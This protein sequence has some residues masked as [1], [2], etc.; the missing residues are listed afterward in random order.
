MCGRYVTVTKIR[1]IEQRFGVKA[2][3]PELYLPSPNVSVGQLAPVILSSRPD[4]LRFC[5]FG[6][7]PHWATKNMYVLNARCEGDHNQDDDPRYTGAKGILT[8]PMFRKAIRSQRCLVIADAVIEGP[9]EEKLKKP[10]CVYM[11]DGRR[12]F[13][14]AGIWDEW[15]NQATGELITSFA[16]L[17]TAAN[18]LM[19]Q[20]GHHR[21]PLFLFPHQEKIWLDTQ[22][23]LEEIT[24]MMKPF[25]AEELNA[26]PL[27][28]EIRSPKSRGMELLTPIGV[29]LVAETGFEVSEEIRLFGMG[30]G[31]AKERRQSENQ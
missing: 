10:F 20:I 28:P 15:L 31:R 18:E 3:F 1:E 9:K 26:Y 16:I 17:T 30:E 12:P 6:F 7:T 21:C 24:A 14:L 4:E 27:S 25:P 5:Q 19:M 2:P 29:P 11:R 13:A 8:K 23:P 22:V